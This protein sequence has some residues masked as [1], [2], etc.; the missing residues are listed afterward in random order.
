LTSPKA[1]LASLRIFVSAARLLSFSGAA[2]EHGISPSAVTQAIARL[3]DGIGTMLFTR[4]VRQVSL[5]PAGSKLFAT[6]AS[7]LREIDLAVKSI[8]PRSE[9]LVRLTA[10][11]TWTALWLMPRLIS[12]TQQNPTI[13]VEVD[14]SAAVLDIESEGIDLA[15][16]YGEALPGHFKRVPLFAQR[17]MPICSPSLAQRLKHIGNLAKEC[18]LHESDGSRWNDWLN[19]ATGTDEVAASL[20]DR[21][22]GLYFSQGTLAVA[23][24]MRGLGVAL[25]E[26]AFV[27]EQ[28]R[29]EQLVE[30]FSYRW[31]SGH[32]YHVVW[33]SRQRLGASVRLFLDWLKAEAT[34][35]Q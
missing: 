17:F 26:P 20:W 18:L 24:A 30:P 8:S 35:D 23:A 27:T 3:E 28:I 10:P 16:R 1:P 14:A 2:R 29:R 12:F 13:Q 32:H 22:T 9:A 33:S 6:A 25:T 11:P 31:H 4:V 5:T 34:L 15:V 19:A 21:A 7:A